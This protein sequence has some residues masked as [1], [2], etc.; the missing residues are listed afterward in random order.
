MV[1]HPAGQQ[2]VA[3]RGKSEILKRYF[4]FWDYILGKEILISL[5]D[6]STLFSL[7]CDYIN[8]DKYS[9]QYNYST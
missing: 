7:N 5:V 1:K 3:N 9:I 4:F 2:S 6:Y 8:K